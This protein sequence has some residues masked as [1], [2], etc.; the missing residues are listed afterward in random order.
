MDAHAREK[1]TFDSIANGNWDQAIHHAQYVP[2]NYDIWQR[3]PSTAEMPDDA[4][5][6]VLDVLTDKARPHHKN[7]ASFI[8]EYS[9]NIPHNA[10]PEILNRIGDVHMKN[11]GTWHETNNLLAHP[12]F[13][14]DE[15]GESLKRAADFW[16]EY[17][18]KVG[19]HHFAT[20]KSMFTGEPES[21]TD[22]RGKSAHSGDHMHLI[23]DLRNHSKAVQDLVL[24]DES[25]GKKYI[26]GKPHIQLFRGV[27]GHYGKM[28]WDKSN[29]DPKNQLVDNK[30][31]MIPTAHLTSWTTDPMMARRFAWGRGNIENQ[32]Q[33][34]GVIMSQWIPVDQVIHSGHHSTV[35]GQEHPH[36]SEN[37]IVVGHPQ[38][39]YK[40]STK[41][42]EFQQAPRYHHDDQPVKAPIGSEAPTLST[43]QNYGFTDI[44]LLRKTEEKQS[45]KSVTNSVQIDANG[46]ELNK[47]MIG[48]IIPAATALALLGAPQEYTH[49]LPAEHMPAAVQQVTQNPKPVQEIQRE[50]ASALNPDL[51]A[52]NMVESSGGLQTR[53]AMMHSG[54]HKGTR[55]YGRFGLMPMVIL[56]TI[57]KNPALAN[58]YPQF[59][60]LNYKKDHAK[61]HKLMSQSPQAEVDIANTHWKKLSNNF[62]GDKNKMAYAWLNGVAG[63]KRT[64]K[65]TIDN[66]DYVQKF[67]KYKK[68][69]DLEGKIVKKSETLEPTANIEQFIGFTSVPQDEKEVKNIND[70]I[71]TNRL[72]DLS[73]TGKFT[74][75]SFV[76]GFDPDNSWLIKLEPFGQ[77]PASPSVQHGLQTVKEAAFYQIADKVF[78]LSHLTP[79]AIL[80]E[81]IKDNSH[82]PAVAI[83]MYPKV[84]ISADDM[85]KSKP[86]SMRSILEKYRRNGDLHKMAALLYIL[87]DAD[88]HGNNLLTD[89]TN[90]KMIDHGTSFADMDFN[91]A[92]DDKVFVPYI[93]RAWGYKDHMSPQEKYDVMP[94]LD[95]DGVRQDLTHWIQSIDQHELLS[96]LDKFLINP[97]APLSRL[98]IIQRMSQ[99]SPI[100]KVIN[101]LW[102]SDIAKQEVANEAHA[103]GY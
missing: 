67:N 79:K 75:D 46:V 32:P 42:M 80:G 78:G 7:L 83:K 70:A 38:G 35:I 72:H 24:N 59:L 6:K 10:S 73:N 50:P 52:I 96:L 23:P 5:H 82:V 90:I 55:A 77:H 30:T 13:K 102:T 97:K 65:E 68:M 57:N 12:N 25:I 88:A 11:G 43:A 8:F 93:L 34:K 36:E 84:F 103:A 86:H 58:K 71:K 1:A 53:H 101:H 92:D 27:G 28:L 22:H 17:E 44:P 89:G 19:P 94:T 100:D 56:E 61:I 81:V 76:A 48:K 49:A 3:M 15:R 39:K 74:H 47:S 54:P 91:P 69:L 33:D 26:Q 16:K 18:Q 85:E 66:H 95:N 31:F 60:G 2:T 45:F 29:Y 63:T 64:P 87:G 62:G 51:K 9:H 21:L 37:E 40:V 4:V 41:N 98:K 99:I 20:V 14:Y